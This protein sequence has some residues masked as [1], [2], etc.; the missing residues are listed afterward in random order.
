MY[1]EFSSLP[2]ECAHVTDNKVDLLYVDE[3]I[4]QNTPSVMASGRAYSGSGFVE[5]IDTSLY[6]SSLLPMQAPNVPNNKTIEVKTNQTWEELHLKADFIKYDTSLS[7]MHHCALSKVRAIRDS[8]WIDELTRA[9]FVEYCLAPYWS[10]VPH[11]VNPNMGATYRW[12][13][14]SD[15][16]CD[17]KVE[18]DGTHSGTGHCK[19]VESVGACHRVVF[20]QNR[21]G[22][23]TSTQA[24]M[25]ARADSEPGD[26]HTKGIILMVICISGLALT[27]IIESTEFCYSFTSSARRSAYLS[28][29]SMFW[30]GLDLLCICGLVLTL[31]R[32]PFDHQ[33]FSPASLL[34]NQ[35][36]DK[37]MGWQPVYTQF[38]KLEALEL[39]RFWFAITSLMWWIR[40]IEYFGVFPVLQLPVIAIWYSMST[41]MSFLAFFGVLLVGASMCFRFLFGSSSHAFADLT[42]S[43]MSMLLASI[44]EFRTEEIMVDYRHSDAEFWMLMWAIVMSFI[45]LT[46]F[47]AIIDQGYQDAKESLEVHPVTGTNIHVLT[48]HISVFSLFLCFFFFI[49]Y[50]D[51]LHSISLFFL[52]FFFSISLFFVSLFLCFFFFTLYTLRVLYRFLLF[53]RYT[54]HG[55]VYQW[56]G[57][58]FGE[59]WRWHNNN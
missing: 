9:V 35:H 11:D 28:P 8:G 16:F 49:L 10:I 48:P 15:E 19:L 50:K 42:S 18:K 29:S 53:H 51:I 13:R 32:F 23:V 22:R 39:T 54:R 36:T 21:Y 24:V 12:E 59:C 41:V 26:L 17:Y 34:F 40:G 44:G 56:E 43:T 5:A 4:S 37:G 20:E 45:V 2:P 58:W 14:E 7:Q 57:F 47:V 55:Q 52:C 30:N 3:S 31:L 46:M 6:N 33:P 38:D 27:V 1:T 25:T